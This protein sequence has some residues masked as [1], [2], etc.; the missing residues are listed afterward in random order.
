MH[1]GVGNGADPE[2]TDSLAGLLCR[3][4]LRLEQLHHLVAELAPNTAR[5]RQQ[6]EAIQLDRI[7]MI[8]VS[9]G[10]R[11]L[12]PARSQPFAQMEPFK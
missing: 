3:S 12:I 4:T 2:P 10:P 7:G 11:S 6:Q 9:R 1:E 8:L 5:K